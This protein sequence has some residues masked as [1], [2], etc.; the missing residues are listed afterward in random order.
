MGITTKP[1][2]GARAGVRIAES[3][4]FGVAVEL[5]HLIEFVSE[6]LSATENNITSEAIRPDRGIHKLVRGNLAVGGDIN[7]E[8]SASGLG[9]LHKHALGDYIRVPGAD[10]GI[11]GR[12]KTDTE[13]EPAAVDTMNPVIIEFAN[14]QSSVFADPAALFAV[15]YRDSNDAL[16]ADDNANA[17]FAYTSYCGQEATYVTA[18][19]N[20]D[21]T[22]SGGVTP[23]VLID[24]ADV[25]DADGNLVA[26]DFNPNGGI[27]YLGNNRTRHVY[28]EYLPGAGGGANDSQMW[29]DP[30]TTTV[31][32]AAG[33]GGNPSVND[34]AIGSACLAKTGGVTYGLPADAGKGT[35][36]YEFNPAWMHTL[37]GGTGT[38]KADTVFTHHFERGVEL[39]P[40]GLTVEIDRDAA[41][42]LY[43]G[44]KVGTMTM[45]FDA[46]AIVTGTFSVVGQ[47][48]FSIATLVNDAV[49]GVATITVDKVDAFP[50]DGGVLTI[51]EE[52]DITYTGIT[53]N[54]DNWD[55]NGIPAAGTASIQRFH[56]KGQN[57]DSRSSKKAQLI[58]FDYDTGVG[59]FTL[60]ETVNLG[61]GGTAQLV[62]IDDNGATGSMVIRMITSPVPVDNE[63]VTGVDSAATAAVNTPA[64]A[65]PVDIS[66]IDG[67]NTPLTAFESLVYIDGA[68]EEVLNG[69][70]TLNN[71]LNAD[72]FGLGSRYIFQLVEE[73]AEVEA[74]LTL[75]FDDG[76]NYRKFI[77]GT[78][79][80]LEF[81]AIS[82]ADDSEIDSL[83][84]MSGAY[85][86]MCKCKY[87]GTT[88]VVGGP[89]FIQHDMPVS[90][91]VDDDLETTDLI[92]ILVNNNPY[93][94]ELD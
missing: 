46:N 34:G 30:T 66:D 68:F 41:M 59:T 35:I 85:Y 7:V 70:F 52:T 89:S 38:V 13:D 31:G 9:M 12:R 27:V 43:T 51:G 45:T 56:P 40:A 37:Y 22:H 67:N 77:E 60:D 87:N 32:G 80:S 21:A 17:G 53:A 48:E 10:G 6:S 19:L 76:K 33:V 11:H 29:L 23:T 54:G 83:G 61:G 2:V 20:S 58:E 42:F 73:R 1:A 86:L 63:T 84:V 71:N 39:P 62:H 91:I 50:L 88:P 44:V 94:V 75:E 55:I 8:L 74:S 79:F 65:A 18:F 14:D 25:R 16:V 24:L 15:V 26:P 82:E 57:V 5:T 93:D 4:T 64:P 69:S 92:A 72:K 47:K 3:A 78:F 36:V 90:C 81:K 49:P 28:M